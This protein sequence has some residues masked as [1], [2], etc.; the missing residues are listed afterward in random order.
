MT[1]TPYLG[2]PLISSQQLQPEV[3]H[4]TAIMI[5]QALSLGAIAK[6]NAPPGAPADG[7]CYII[8]SAGSGAWAGKSNK[9]AIYYGGW[10]FCPGV[11][12]EGVNLPMGANQRGLTIFLRSADGL[13]T[14][15]GAHWYGTDPASSG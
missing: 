15:D 1:T 8:G 3:T 12:S 9:I 11:D 10:I 6:Q 4:N 5:M 7:D 13:V 14:W 2:I